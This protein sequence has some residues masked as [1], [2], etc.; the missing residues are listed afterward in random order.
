MLKVA[1][2][3]AAWALA[4]LPACA[5]PT[6]TQ[7]MVFGT[8]HFA[9]QNLDLHNVKVVDV[10]TPARQAEVA[11]LAAALARFQPTKIA[12]E[13]ESA[14]PDLSLDLYRQFTPAVLA[15]N[16]R[17]QVQLG[18]RIAAQLHLPAVY[19]V[20]EKS[21][22]GGY[23][24]F[25]FGDVKDWADKNGHAAELDALGGRAAAMVQ[26]WTDMQAGH[27]FMEVAAVINDPAAIDRD[28]RDG[29][30]GTLPFG[31]AKTQPG[32]VLNGMWYL[33]N[34]R[35]FAKIEQISQPGDRVLVIFGA[36]HAYWLR[37][38]AAN[39]PGFALVEPLGYLT[40]SKASADSVR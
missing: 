17:E 39:A 26:R 10:L 16:R 3:A 33:R 11:A 22:D 29:Y 30:Y 24:Y 36:G 2:A 23:D 32:A 6:V 15:S 18:F 14:A 13:Y 28:F 19:G 31:D 12:V 7:I 40:A 27:S 25:P 21:H 37:H 8:D 20:D 4:A 35:I 9:N 1:L 5:A 38:F 34:A